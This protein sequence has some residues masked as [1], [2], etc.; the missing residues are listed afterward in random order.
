MDVYVIPVA[1]DRY[2]L[3]CEHDGPEAEADD[4]EPQGRFGKMY[5]NFKDALARVEQERLPS[6][7]CYGGCARKPS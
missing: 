6:S 2:E 3:Y 5:A 4:A 1:S 7:G